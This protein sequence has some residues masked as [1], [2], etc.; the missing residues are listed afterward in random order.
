MYMNNNYRKIIYVLLALLALLAIFGLFTA[1]SR[2]GKT[3]LAVM[4]VPE[5]TKITIN[6]QPASVGDNYIK[7]G[8]Y[9]VKASK[10]GFASDEVVVNLAKTPST[11]YLIP[12]PVSAEA[13]QWFKDNPD[14]QLKREGI[15]GQR[16][17]QESKYILANNEII[18]LLPVTVVEEGP[19]SLDYG[20]NP[21]VKN[22]VFIEVS[23][24]S[25][26]GRV[27]ALH[28]IRSHGF[29]PTDLDIRFDDFSNPLVKN[30][31]PLRT[32]VD[33]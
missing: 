23:D 6:N 7:P 32:G 24:S 26:E 18:R 28:W 15:A 3:K 30:V 25:P 13:K 2:I 8:K 1:I 10:K 31:M 19:F 12:N 9:T 5:D 21:N 17:D 33:E 27:N 20:T 11:A 4:S 29:D 22:K 16:T 14:Q